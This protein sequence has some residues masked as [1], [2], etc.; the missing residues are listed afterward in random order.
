[1]AAPAQFRI[2]FFLF[3]PREVG[4]TSFLCALFRQLYAQR[5]ARRHP[6]PRPSPGVK[7]D[8]RVGTLGFSAGQSLQR[9]WEQHGGGW[10]RRQVKRTET[11]FPCDFAVSRTPEKG[12]PLGMLFSTSDYE[13]DLAQPS[14]E[15]EEDASLALRMAEENRVRAFLFLIDQRWVAPSPTPREAQRAKQ[16]LGW[17]GTVLRIFR[18]KN[19]PTHLPVAL[20]VNK[21]DDILKD[22]FAKLDPRRTHLIPAGTQPAL[23]HHGSDFR[24]LPPTPFE[25]L[26][27]CVV[28]DLDNNRGEKFQR[29]VAAVMDNC[30]PFFDELLQFTYRYQIFLTSTLAPDPEDESGASPF[31][32]GVLEPIK[33]LAEELY[34]PFVSQREQQVA[35]EVKQLD[36]LLRAVPRR[37]DA[38]KE[39]ARQLKAAE[40]QRD[41]LSAEFLR[42][43]KD[44]SENVLKVAEGQIERRAAEKGRA[45][46]EAE[47]LAGVAAGRKDGDPRQEKPSPPR[48]ATTDQDRIAAVEAELAKLETRRQELGGELL[49]LREERDR[50]TG[51]KRLQ[52]VLDRVGLLAKRLDSLAGELRGEFHDLDVEPEHLAEAEVRL[53]DSQ[54]KLDELA[55]SLLEECHDLETLVR[56]PE[57]DD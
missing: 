37:L 53:H 48:E 15:P 22:D 56:S 50:I 49:T 3:G 14:E 18:E 31:P 47:R 51:G 45:L 23:V 6:G 20:V 39:A 36:K 54:E 44:K 2:P 43:K 57:Q 11:P 8:T 4:K 12:T 10:E 46:A 38:H 13:G 7:A 25:R 55:H 40:K 33:W 32:Y 21:I 42:T 27:E 9:L 30:E 5:P 26:R 1:M 41:D 35:G 19:G 52:V 34:L 17:Y 16:W 24:P 29:M 28:E